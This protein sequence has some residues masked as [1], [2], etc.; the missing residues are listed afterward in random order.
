[1]FFLAWL[2]A[3]L[4][5][6]IVTRIVVRL[7]FLPRGRGGRA[8]LRGHAWSSPSPSWRSSP[9]PSITSLT[10]I[11]GNAPTIDDAIA[12][13]S[14]PSR[15]RSTS[16]ACD[17]PD[18]GRARPDPV[19]GRRT[20]TVPDGGAQQG[21]RAVQPGHRD[22]LHRGRLRRQQGPLPGVLAAAGA[23]RTGPSCST[24]SRGHLRARSAASSAASSA[25]RRSTA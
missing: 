19:A 7:P 3:F 6:P 14:R 21:P 5:D 2:L 23:A 12:K 25:W 1:M 24:S 4:L 17:Q 18:Q 13:L 11:V 20:R 15:R 22:H 9:R 16:S 8:R 10:Q